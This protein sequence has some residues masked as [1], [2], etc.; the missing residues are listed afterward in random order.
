MILDEATSSV[1]TQT[2][3]AIQENINILSKDKTLV[4]IAHRLSTVRNADIIYVL[5]QGR[6]VESGTHNELVEK[7]EGI[8][9]DL[10]KVQT[11]EKAL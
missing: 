10:W 9:K 1:D 7:S 4:I 11:G 3:Q 2:E 5:D 8:Y 6:V